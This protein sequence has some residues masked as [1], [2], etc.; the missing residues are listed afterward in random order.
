MRTAFVVMLGLL[1]QAKDEA[2]V[3]SEFEKEFKSKETSKRVEALKKLAGCHEEKTLQALAGAMKDAEKDV[4]KAAAET[5]AACTDGAGAAIKA[6]CAAL[7][8]KKE[9]AEVRLACAKALTKASYK[10]EAVAAMIDTISGI[11][12]SDRHLHV[13]GKDVTVLLEGV[14]KESHG[15]GKTTPDLWQA[16]WKENRPKYEKEDEARRAESKKEQK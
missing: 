2:K 11:Q 5:I 8:D 6:L 3:R 10:T 9:D 13:F 7:V 14:T 16:W 12:N 4:K 15:Y 1:A